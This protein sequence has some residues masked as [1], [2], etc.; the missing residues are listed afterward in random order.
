MSL[1]GLTPSASPATSSTGGAYIKDV[2]QDSFSKEVIEASMTAPVIVDF[3]APWCGPCKTLTPVLEAAVAKLRGAVTL[4][5]VNIDQNQ[6]LA[7]QLRVQSIPM[8]YAFYQGQGVDGFQGALPGSQ[9]EAFVQKVAALGETGAP[10][11]DPAHLAAALDQGRALLAGGQ[12][13]QAEALAAQIVEA[14]GSAPEALA[15]MGQIYL[16]KGD[17]EG[18]E[19]FLNGLDAAAQ[20]D[21]TIISLR[22]SMALA[23]EAQ[24]LPP[25]AALQAQ[26]AATPEDNQTRFDYARALVAQGRGQEAIDTLIA[27]IAQDPDWQ[28]GA[29]KSKLF[30]FFEVFGPSNPLT[31]RG[32]RQ[33]SSLLFA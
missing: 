26:L 23:Q 25:L 3:W 30:Q 7:A 12:V 15:F 2:S 22:A 8:V 24:G 13:D 6:A 16:T 5:K 19:V 18:L 9:V 14:S 11:I 28:D 31:V 32:R 21:P 27:L 1:I 10:Q 4:A 20:K 33:L 29:A 17:T